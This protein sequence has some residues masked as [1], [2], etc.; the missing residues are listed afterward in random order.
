MSVPELSVFPNTMLDH[1]YLS[2]FKS[3]Q[4][5][6]WTSRNAAIRFFTHPGYAFKRLWH[7]YLINWEVLAWLT[8]QTSLIWQHQWLQCCLRLPSPSPQHSFQQP[9]SFAWWK[10]KAEFKG[11]SSG[12]SASCRQAESCQGQFPLRECVSNRNRLFLSL[13]EEERWGDR[14]DICIYWERHKSHYH[15]YVIQIIPYSME[16]TTAPLSSGSEYVWSHKSTF[17][18]IA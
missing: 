6:K 10:S 4:G 13:F 15:L 8:P 5:V 17:S 2:F 18:S 3:G 1:I 16:V 11:P 7:T 12:P 9:C 14:K